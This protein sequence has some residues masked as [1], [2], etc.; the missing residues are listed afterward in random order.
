MVEVAM[1]E[2]SRAE[3][4]SNILTRVEVA[5]GFDTVEIDT[6]ELTWDV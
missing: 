1:V 4:N 6:Q 2:L 3:I 5:V